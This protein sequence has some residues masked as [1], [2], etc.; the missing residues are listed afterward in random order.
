MVLFYST[1]SSYIKFNEKK[2][3][4]LHFSIS[5]PLNFGWNGCFK[6]VVEFKLLFKGFNTLHSLFKILFFPL[7]KRQG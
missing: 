7:C 2:N 4:I 5:F 3:R 1:L 6:P